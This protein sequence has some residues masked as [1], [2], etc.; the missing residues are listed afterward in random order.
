MNFYFKITLLLI[1]TFGRP[2]MVEAAEFVGTQQCADCHQQEYKAWQGS[3]H[4]M[5][6]RHAKPDAVLGDF[7]DVTVVFNGK[8]NRFFQKGQQYWVNIEGPDGKFHDY[9]IKYTFAFKPLQ[10]YMVE[11]DDGR[12][13]LIPFAWD[14]RTKSEG[15]QRWFHL[16]PEY[17]Q[18]HQDYFW[19]NTGQ[20][21][22]YMCADCHSTDV[23]K[24]F[25]VDSNSYK[26]TY[27]EINVGCEACHGPASDHITW[28]KSE[29]GNQTDI[30]F[31]RKLNKSVMNWVTRAG[32]K[33]LK[34]ETVEHSQQTLVC[35]QCHSRH[36]QISDKDHVDSNEF[37]ERYL[38]NL[39]DSQ[40]Y[41]PDG[42]IYDEDFVYGS[43]LQSK[44]SRSGVVCS[45]CHD[46]H[47]AELIM[48][49]EVVCLQCH[50]ADEYANKKH[51]NHQGDS[52]GA[53]CV[54]CHMPET[55]YMQVDSRRDHAWHVPRPDLA[56]QLGTPDTCLSCHKEKDST[57]SEGFTKQWFPNSK[58]ATDKHFAPVFAAADQGY[59]SA[60]N[61]LSHIAQNSAN[62]EI[63]RAAALV[64]MSKFPETNTL[65][66]IVRALK[67]ENSHIRVGAIHGAV[68][69]AGAERWR[70]LA[71]LL[72]DP[73]LSVRSEA[74]LALVPLWSE[75]AKGQKK[76]LQ[77]A[78]DDYMDIQTFNADRGYAHVN[79]GNVYARQGKLK[80]AE[81]AYKTSIRIEENF[82][83]AY[84]HLAELYRQ[85]QNNQAGIDILQKGLALNPDSGDLAYSLGLVYIRTKQ[86][87]KAVE[88]FKQAINKSPD[89]AQYAYVYGL[90]LESIQ[91][92]QALTALKKA[93]EL[94]RNPQHLFALC[95]MQIRHQSPDAKQCINELSQYAPEN[96]I[97]KLKAQNRRNK[98]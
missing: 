58:I 53:Q 80:Q 49:E 56:K 36:V 42:Q 31:D 71:P 82:V 13:Q 23:K 81:A 9:Q 10:Q 79:K 94:S 8:N 24:N 76:L 46:P 50:Q 55:T 35:A 15:G 68:G 6:M 39:I 4:D 1:F 85:Q 75:L 87:N 74:A 14:S 84:I 61:S 51:H 19:T 95:E 37:G 65:I 30:G 2:A 28:S 27:S 16:Y 67:N 89:N 78:L 43:F 41:Y 38:L 72:S 93:F 44:M 40:Q 7:N 12:V 66:A 47:S 29:Q 59:R 90:S 57:W 60:A 70:I 62:A 5:A 25:D 97:N 32:S 3:H 91:P 63:I 83:N 64:R 33:T 73:V 21:W 26:T 45:N 48:P 69:I 52:Q 17:T 22:N 11:F 86:S 96:I 92:T 54:N 20:N 18:S 34:P 98:K 77:P 88:Q